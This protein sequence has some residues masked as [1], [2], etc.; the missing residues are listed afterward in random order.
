MDFMF[1]C[2]RLKQNIEVAKS[3]ITH[4]HKFL[5]NK[6]PKE[7]ELGEY[8]NEDKDKIAIIIKLPKIV[9][10]PNITH[11]SVS[12]CKIVA[13][14][15]SNTKVLETA[16]FGKNGIVYDEALGY[17]DVCIQDDEYALLEEINRLVK[18]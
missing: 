9:C 7:C 12:A 5:G 10:N 18:M 4:V 13:L 17:Y 11:I 16:L 15:D 1:D 8:T 6:L 3:R 2:Q 14:N